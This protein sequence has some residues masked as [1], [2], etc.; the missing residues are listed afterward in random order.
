MADKK[1]SEKYLAL[2]NQ[3]YIKAIVSTLSDNE[4]KK[5]ILSNEYYSMADKK[6][7]KKYLALENQICD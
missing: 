3:T 1:R 4:M 7:S 5:K 2:K 6:H